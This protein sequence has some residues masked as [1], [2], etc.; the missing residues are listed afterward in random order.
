MIANNAVTYCVIDINYIK[1]QLSKGI[2]TLHNDKQIHDLV[3]TAL[4]FETMQNALSLQSFFWNEEI[5]HKCTANIIGLISPHLS[6][7]I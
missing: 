1:K 6:C 3:R 7:C 4:Y 5:P 2:L